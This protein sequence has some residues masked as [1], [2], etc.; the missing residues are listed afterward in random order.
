MERF[1]LALEAMLAAD[2]EAKGL[3]SW[4]LMAVVDDSARTAASLNDFLWT[5]FTRS[6]P[7]C[8]IYG[9][10]ASVCCKHWGCR[11]P[12]V[13]DARAKPHHAPALEEDPEVEKRVD[14]LAARGG[15]LHGVI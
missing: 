7:A 4:P 2:G 12:L 5:C 1:C 8:D 6:D 10:G 13:I 3:D 9:V 15:P 14:R 11:G